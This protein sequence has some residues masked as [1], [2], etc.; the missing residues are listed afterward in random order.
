MKDF[1]N[2]E[3]KSFCPRSRW[4]IIRE[5]ERKSVCVREREGGGV[6]EGTREIGRK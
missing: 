6:S 2:Y 3:G 1:G 5:R 4:N